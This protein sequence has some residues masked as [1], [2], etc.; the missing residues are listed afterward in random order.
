[1]EDTI[2]VVTA[3]AFRIQDEYNNL[4]TST[5]DE[6][7]DIQERAF[8][9][10]ELLKLAVNL[11]YVD[12]IGRRKM[13]QLAR[14]SIRFVRYSALPRWPT[15]LFDRVIRKGLDSSE[16]RGTGYSCSGEMVS[17]ANL[18][19]ALIPRCLDIL[20]KTSDGERDLMRVVVDVVTELREGEGDEDVDMV[21][22]CRSAP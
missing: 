5:N 12:E 10:G 19:E 21:S 4:V 16:V 22:A 1:M 3:L 2:P 13:F 9:V 8:M 7:E 6:A 17:Q 18:P 14:E 15:T 11:D 20:S